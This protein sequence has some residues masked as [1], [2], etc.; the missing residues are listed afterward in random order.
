MK[1]LN[2][3]LSYGSVCV[4]IERASGQIENSTCCWLLLVQSII[5]FQLLREAP[6]KMVEDN[7]V[8]LSLIGISLC[9]DEV[10]NVAR[11]L[12][13]KCR[14]ILCCRN[15]KCEPIVS[16]R[17]SILSL[18]VTKQWEMSEKISSLMIIQFDILFY[19]HWT[20]V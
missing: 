15:L 19:G 2:K 13:W 17:G 10:P 3:K 1:F 5:I 9:G 11:S 4:E 16:G 7:G 18:S 12:R 20:I 6:L 14:Q 8:T